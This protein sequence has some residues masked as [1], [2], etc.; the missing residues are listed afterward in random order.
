MLKAFV[1]LKLCIILRV[2]LS[3]S[4]LY[5]LELHIDKSKL[6]F[7]SNILMFIS[8]FYKDVMLNAIVDKFRSF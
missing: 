4:Y 8:S 1:G 7:K 5:A 3:L 6:K 2:G